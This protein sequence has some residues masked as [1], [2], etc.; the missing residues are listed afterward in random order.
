MVEIP[1]LG[2]A[3]PATAFCAEK[4]TSQNRGVL[5]NRD[6]VLDLPAAFC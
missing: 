4:I 5:R 2:F 1:F 6:L 3:G